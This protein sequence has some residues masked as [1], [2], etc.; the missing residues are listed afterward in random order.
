[1]GGENEESDEG[2]RWRL[3]QGYKKRTG[4]KSGQVDPVDDS[5]TTRSDPDQKKDW[6]EAGGTWELGWTLAARALSCLHSSRPSQPTHPGTYQPPT[7]QSPSSDREGVPCERANTR[8][9][10]LVVLPSG[11][12]PGHECIPRVCGLVRLLAE[13]LDTHRVL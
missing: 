1:M 4:D 9:Q 8:R 3:E 12:G 5:Q 2:R 13:T 6:L 10:N 11:K 7:I